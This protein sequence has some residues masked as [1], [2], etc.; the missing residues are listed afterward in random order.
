MIRKFLIDKPENKNVIR[1]GKPLI[2]AGAAVILLFV[3]AALFGELAYPLGIYKY[4]PNQTNLSLADI[5]P[6]N[7]LLRNL[8]VRSANFNNNFYESNTAGDKNYFFAGTDAEGRDILI[9]VFNG[10]ATYLIGG[11]IAILIAVILGLALGAVTG[12]YK[13]KFLYGTGL[14]FIS[15]I[16]SFP[17]IV[18]LILIAFVYNFNFWALMTT[19]GIIYSTK[20]GRLIK[21]KIEVLKS[22]DFILAAKE[23]GLSDNKIIFKHIVWYN[24]KNE[25]LV[26]MIY[27][28]AA[29]ILIEAT[30]GYIGYGVAGNWVSW[31][32]MIYEGIGGKSALR[33]M[34]GMYWEFV[35]PAVAMVVSIL[36]FNLFAYGLSGWFKIKDNI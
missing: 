8:L 20:F 10:A 13:D 30:L 29:V 14:F 9:R 5:P 24:C 27:V 17:V 2:I 22:S 25:I 35:P 6:S 26:Q 15:I 36:G 21:T 3:F 28:F 19:I 34:N 33:L 16:E 18:I 4:S 23:L 1:K 12:Y 11:S 7:K 31:G 32:K